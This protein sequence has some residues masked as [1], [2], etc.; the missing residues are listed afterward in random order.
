MPLL[1]F[2][3]KNKL[4]RE[5]TGLLI[6]DVQEKL[7]QLED[8][9]VEVLQV[10]QK[11]I[12]G[13]QIL[14]LPIFVTE[15]YPEGLGATVPGIKSLLGDDQCY[16]PKTAFSCMGDVVIRK[17]LEETGLTQWVILGIEAHVCV[18][19]TAKDLLFSG[20]ETV[21]LNDAITSRSVYDFA[22]AIAEMRDYG[23]RISSAETVLFELIADSTAP[24]FKKI[25]QL[26]K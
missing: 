19:Q 21:V 20:F 23:I 12:K 25:S 22:T 16:F 26:I 24:E 5:K 9:S 3:T 15:Q 14:G 4:S 8:R 1:N 7:I 2:M 17:K 18:L 10:I 13:F 6:I 11:V